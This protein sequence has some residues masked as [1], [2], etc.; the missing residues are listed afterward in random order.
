MQA[1]A[2]RPGELQADTD[3][4]HYAMGACEKEEEAIRK[5]VDFSITA[6]RARRQAVDWS[7]LTCEARFWHWKSGPAKAHYLWW[8]AALEEPHI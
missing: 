7:G 1:V 5:A 8:P 4:I 2:V 6:R 3:L